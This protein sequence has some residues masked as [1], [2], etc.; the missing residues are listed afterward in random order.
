MNQEEWQKVRSILESA[1]QLHPDSRPAFVDSACAG[2][3]R[4]RREVLSL[5]KD[6]EKPDHFLEEPAL[7]MVRRHMSQ[8]Q[9]QRDKEAESA[10]LGKKISHYR[11]LQRLGGGGMG[12]VYKAEDTRLGRHVALKF[13]PEEMAHDEQALERFKREAQAAS[14]LSHPHI[15][16]IYDIGEYEGGPFIVMELLEGST[17]KHR[18]SGQ[19]LACELVVELAIHIAEAL[20]AA[21][22]KGILH[23][24][25]KPA[26]IFVTE[27][28]ES[29]LLDFGL[30]KLAGATVETLV[31]QNQATATTETLHVQDLTLPGALMGTVPYM[32]PEQI[33]GEP[34]D[35]RSDIFSFGAV[36]YEMA[37]GRPAFSGKTTGQIREAILTLEPASPRKLNPHVPVAL[38]R[39]IATALRKKTEERYQRAAELRADLVRVRA[40]NDTRWP[41][42]AAVAALALIALLATMTWKLGWLRTGVRP[43]QIHSIAVLPLTNLSGDPEQEYFADG[44][45]EQ[46]T[47]DLG[48]ISALRVISRTS[49][50]HYKGTN[51]RVPEIARELDVDAV[52]EGSVERSG[53]QVRITAQLIEA[54]TDRHLWAKSYERDLRDILALQDQVAKVIAGEVRTTLTPQEQTRLTSA[55]SVNPEAYQAYLK[56]RFYWN[57]RTAEGL[58]K[59]L[60][61][62]Q[63]AIGADPAD[64]RAYSGLADSYNML[65][66]WNVYP[67]AEVAPKA[68][69][70]ARK[71]LE[72]DEQLAEAHASLAWSMFAFDWDWTGAEK[73]L[74]RAIEL[75]PGYETAH[76]WLSNCLEQQGRMDEALAEA[77]L[78]VNL[79]PL[80]LVNNAVL[81]GDL[82]FGGKIE[83]A[84]EQERK[85]LELADNFAWAHYVLGLAY[86]Q[87]GSL[88]EAIRELQQAVAIDTN[89]I[90]RSGL[91]HAF[92]LAGRRREA[93]ELL[94]AMKALS[95]E[96]NIGWYDIAVIY[97][98]F[99]E[100][101]KTLAAL[102]IA[103]KNHSS[104]LNWVKVDPRFNHLHN[105]P[106]FETLLRQMNLQP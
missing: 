49:A 66:L 18:I 50:M 86:E 51:K 67:Q 40:E 92:V 96:R 20:E 2:D 71:A 17:L 7:Q 80:S 83:Q 75:N 14:A 35:A 32:S 61:Y 38:E 54:P 93:Q 81:G 76:R 59:S 60:G 39:V 104:H 97:A 43:G 16:T 33:R 100:N 103:H 31:S 15:C 46:L 28:G 87:R 5:L 41:R 73:E 78:A 62:F 88:E 64:S 89:S 4:L 27:R 68:K 24:D 63:Q 44:M 52:V 70:A 90:Y 84:I 85:T 37:T 55:R 8:D 10:L 19:A 45:T 82:F 47:T 101:N 36:L 30:A 21:H 25:I 99:G 42:R 102:E 22:A 95:K 11:I 1:L 9:T 72:I 3:D 6:Q 12:V 105:D 58:K 26:N 56:G 57:K 13:L 91:G 94:E 77:K 48:Q 98:A 23:R 69:A 74:K 79:D 53:N 65:G 106:R 34:V 29:K